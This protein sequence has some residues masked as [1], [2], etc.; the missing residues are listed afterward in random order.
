MNFQNEENHP[1]FE[2]SHENKSFEISLNS[3]VFTNEEISP[4][5]TKEINDNFFIKLCLKCKKK[6]FFVPLSNENP[7]KYQKPPP[8]LKAFILLIVVGFVIIIYSLVYLFTLQ[9]NSSKFI[10]SF[11]S[12]SILITISLICV[13][14]TN[15]FFIFLIRNNIFSILFSYV[16]NMLFLYY[17][18]INAKSYVF[19]IFF[20]SSQ[21]YY[22]I[23]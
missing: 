12:G 3:Q 4:S 15:G 23:L 13:K 10:C 11:F 16:F 22:T 5:R 9:E 14:G 1:K 2:K 19:S 18:V 8:C 17:F 7:D 20:T 21:V 6:E